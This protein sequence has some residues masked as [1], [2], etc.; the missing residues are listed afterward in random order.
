MG[1]GGLRHVLAASPAVKRLGVHFIEGRVDPRA[2]P[3]GCVKSRPPP[4]FH[5]RTV[6]T[7]AGRYTTTLTPTLY[8]SNL[9]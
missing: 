6:Q 7:V 8:F 5:P 9:R 1:V 2:G 3:Y 4:G